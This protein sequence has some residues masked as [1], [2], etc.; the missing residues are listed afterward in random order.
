MKRR[1]QPLRTY[2]LLAVLTAS[3]TEPTPRDSRR[4]QLTRMYAGLRA[5]E[6]EQSPTT[7]DWRLCSDAVNL[8]ETLV[9]Q[10]HVQDTSGLLPDAV[11]ALAM[12]G[13][14]HYSGGAIRLDCSAGMTT[15]SINGSARPSRQPPSAS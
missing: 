15:G 14:R 1:R 13:R 5:I 10:G 2:T 3:P 9:A 11:M 12:A 7:E 4:H 6:Q 8:L